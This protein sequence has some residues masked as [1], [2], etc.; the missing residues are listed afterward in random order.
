MPAG[1]AEV[2]PG[3]TPLISCTNMSN[4]N[5]VK[6][7]TNVRVRAGGP[8]PVCHIERW[9][10][11]RSTRSTTL[12]QQRLVPNTRSFGAGGSGGGNGSSRRKG[13]PTVRRE[14]SEIAI[15]HSN[16]HASHCSSPSAP[17]PRSVLRPGLI[18]S[19]NLYRS[20][21]ENN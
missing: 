7:E 15:F 12:G 5:P 19:A 20:R 14:L 4:G 1:I 18:C 17:R 16:S 2:L 8:S 3:G 10:P 13:K 9:V 6:C 21:N 11:P